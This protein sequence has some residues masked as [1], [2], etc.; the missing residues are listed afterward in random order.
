MVADQM[1]KNSEFALR[2]I[3]K[4]VSLLSEEDCTETI[5]QA[6]VWYHRTLCVCAYRYLCLQL[7]NA[8]TTV[9]VNQS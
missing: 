2:L 3:L 1:K 7:H 9:P 6:Q 8:N 4:S 5:R